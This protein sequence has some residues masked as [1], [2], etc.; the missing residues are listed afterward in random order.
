M[1]IISSQE[2]RY[3]SVCGRKEYCWLFFKLWKE[4]YDPFQVCMYLCNFPVLYDSEGTLGKWR[5]ESG[6]RV[7]L[8]DLPF[9]WAPL[10]WGWPGIFVVRNMLT[11]LSLIAVIVILFFFSMWAFNFSVIFL[12]YQVWETWIVC[13]W[14]M[15][16][17]QPSMYLIIFFGCMKKF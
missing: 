15:F 17:S 8:S 10:F 2:H 4:L 1:V 14:I 13:L 12:I 16:S 9:P 7:S 11:N 5:L 3:W 6:T